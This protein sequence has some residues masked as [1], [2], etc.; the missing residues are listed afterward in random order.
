MKRLHSH[1]VQYFGIDIHITMPWVAVDS[2]GDLYEFETEPEQK[3]AQWI[4]HY[5]TPYN[6]ICNVDLEGLDWK[7]TK[8]MFVL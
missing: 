8:R 3:P 1:V 7:D 4:A 6:F 2:Q 5:E